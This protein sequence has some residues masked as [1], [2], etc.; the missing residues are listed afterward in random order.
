MENNN[1]ITARGIAQ[2]SGLEIFSNIAIDGDEVLNFANPLFASNIDSATDVATT[3]A[4]APLSAVETTFTAG[5]TSN[6]WYK[7]HTS[8]G[9]YTSINAPDI[10]GNYA[11]FKGHKDSGAVS[12][13]G[14][15][16]KLSGLTVG[17]EY[18]IS[19]VIPY[20]TV[21]GT[22]RV[23]RYYEAGGSIVDSGDSISF[24]MPY[25]TSILSGSFTASTASDIVLIDFTTETAS[26]VDQFI[27]SIS[28][29]GKEEYLVPIYA[30]DMYG[31]AHKILR[32]N[33]ENP[34]LNT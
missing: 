9:S 13:S 25:S 22:I 14:I 8:G 21:A 10:S 20:G 5:F 34:A 26:E 24:T 3:E 33:I 12:F 23:K 6:I 27:Y 17:E 18:F 15:Y 16:Q 32:R 29:K 7:Y 31:N 28:I 11:R 2:F 4:D 19:I 1:Q 30:E